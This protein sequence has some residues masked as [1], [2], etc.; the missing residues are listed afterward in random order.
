MIKAQAKD[1]K[2]QGEEI[3]AL[4]ALIQDGASQRTHSEAIASGN[5]LTSPRSSQTRSTSAGSSQIRK[6][7]PQVQDDRAVSIDMGRFKGAK[8]NLN[9][10]RDGLRAGPKVNKVTVKLTMK[11]LRPG[12]GDGIDVVF[13]DKDEANKAQQHTRS[14]TS[15]LTGARVKGEQWNCTL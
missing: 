13:A 9:V 6:D 11:S 15:S 7:K 12:P 8:N 10:I 1:I 14:L 5:T 4:R 3:K 2:S